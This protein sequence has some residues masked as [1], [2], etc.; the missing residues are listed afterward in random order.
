MALIPID[1]VGQMGIV[2]DINSW[3]LSPNA[4]TD[5]N[6]IR[7]EHGAIQKTP[8]YKEVMA[9]CPV[10]PY[11]I[12]NLEVGSSNYWIIGGLAKIYVHNGSSWTDITRTSGD[13]SATAKEGWTSTVL[14]GVL[15]MANGYDDPQSVSY[16]HLTLPTKRIV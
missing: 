10:A 9:S 4:W 2:K 3:Q 1:N 8:G 12:I 6:N 14:G 11:H 13:Y 16:T 15:I 5:G 7:A